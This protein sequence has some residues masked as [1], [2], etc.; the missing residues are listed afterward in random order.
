[1]VELGLVLQVLPEEPGPTRQWMRADD[2]A[3]GIGREHA[4]PRRKRGRETEERHIT[5]LT[6]RRQG[7]ERDEIRSLT[8]DRRCGG[9]PHA[10]HSDGNGHPPRD[11]R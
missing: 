8:G 3:L 9:G 1:M 4:R 2:T 7:L 10:Q 11:A 6:G 5:G